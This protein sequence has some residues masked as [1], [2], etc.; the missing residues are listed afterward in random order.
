[1]KFNYAMKGL[2]GMNPDSGPLSHQY[3]FCCKTLLNVL[4]LLHSFVSIDRIQHHLSSIVRHKAG[5][6]VDIDPLA[7]V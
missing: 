4:L 5:V 7:V 2:K 6:T 3:V 1:M